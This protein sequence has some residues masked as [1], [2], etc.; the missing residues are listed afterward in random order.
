MSWSPPIL[1]TNRLVLVS[2]TG[3]DISESGLNDALNIEDLEGAPNNWT[4]VL[5]AS[6]EAIGSI[7]FIRWEKDKG[8]AELGFLL[9]HTERRKGYMSEA[10]QAVL[11]FGFEQMFLKT[12]EARSMPQNQASVAL[13]KKMNM[14]CEEHVQAR[15]SSKGLLVDLDVFRIYKN[16]SD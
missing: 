12:I 5:K 11:A 16:E 8:L 15:L 9:K 13:L 10:C 4:I 6:A 14:H 1:K 7:G 2:V 3:E